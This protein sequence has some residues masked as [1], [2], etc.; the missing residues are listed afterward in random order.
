MSKLTPAQTEQYYRVRLDPF[1]LHHSSGCSYRGICP[2]HGGSNPTAL[3]VDLHEGNF[4]CF[5]CGA[6]GGS[7]Y[8]FEQK[9]LAVEMNRIP[10][11]DEV[12]QALEAAI[13]T[14]FVRRIHEEP[15]ARAKVGN[16]LNRK[17]ARDSY[18]YTDELGHEPLHRLAFHRSRR[19][20]VHARRPPLP[21]RWQS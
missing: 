3:W 5:S 17:Q 9:L 6:K 15:V 20:Q 2:I 13:G 21:V 18:R 4:A 10:M 16:G 19:E 11:H 14:P 1:K 12:Q 8:T 7:A